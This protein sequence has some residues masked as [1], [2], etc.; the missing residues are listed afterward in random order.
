LSSDEIRNRAAGN[1]HYEQGR[2]LPIL[3]P[4]QPPITEPDWR[5]V[6]APKSFRVRPP[7]GA[8]NVLIILQDQTCYA[9]P[10]TFGGPINFPTLDKLAAEGLTYTNFHVN[11]LCSPSRSALLTGRNQHQNSQAAVVDG[12]TSYPGDTAMR[13]LSVAPLAEILRQWG[14]CTSMFGKSHETPPWETSVAG[15]F[16]RWP[17]RQGF[18]KFYGFIGGEKSLFAPYLVD[19]TTELGVPRQEGYHFNIDITDRAMAWIKATRSL[20]PDRPFFM[21]YATG[22]AHP[23][24]TPPKEWLDVYKG[25][26]D[27]GWDKLREETLA[28]QIKMGLMPEGTKIAENPPEIAKWDALSDDAKAV[29]SRQMEIYAGYAE[30]TDRECGRLIDAIEEIGELDNTIVIYIAGD[31]G[32]TAIGGLNGTFNEWSNLNGAPEDIPYLK[33]RMHEYGTPASYPNYSVGWAMAGATPATWCINAC[34]GGG[35]NQGMVIR[36][37]KGFKAKGEIR[38]QYTHLIDVAPTILEAAG[39]PEPTMVGGVEQVPMAGISFSYSWD[40][41]KATDRHVT[42]YNECTGNRSIYHD[43]WM[44]CVMHRAPWESHPRVDDYAKDKWELYHVAEDF[45]QATDLAAEYPEKLKELQELFHQECLKYG[46]YPMDDRSFQRLNATNAGRPDIMAGRDEMILYPGMTGMAEN[47]F[48]DTL[49]RSILITAELEI[50]KGGSNGVVLSQGGLFG[51]WSLYVKNNKP[52][53]AYNWLARE[54]YEIEGSEALPEG[55]VQ[56]VYDFTY[57]GGGLHKGG[58][59]VLSINGKKVGEG[60]IEKTQ[61]AVYSLAGETADV[62]MDAYSPVT[63]DYD[64]WDNAFTGTIKI[65]KVKHKEAPAAHDEHKGGGLAHT[66]A[67]PRSG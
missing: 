11:S 20:A 58:T 33:S 23:P 10:S 9:D 42:Q 60:R 44:A 51:G 59:G 15:P 46:V 36:W 4:K 63:D 64:P 56:L 65:I 25:K 47:V 37:P 14:Y 29:L 18:E 45:G 21:Y 7:K 39:I 1:P 8:P 57:D 54:R 24:H 61:G 52:K 43:G 35:Q 28:R 53:F 27:Q 13:P 30:H 31:N 55:K 22:G 38:R 62:G 41:E 32:G 26:F 40:D 50:P 6:P 19:G 16:D 66:S 49:S 34:Q 5:K 12:A 2:V 48:V 3:P 17:A 67:A